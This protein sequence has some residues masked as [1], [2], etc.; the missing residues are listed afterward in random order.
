MPAVFVHGVPTT[1]RVW[2]RVRSLLPAESVA[3]ALP[4]MGA[5]RPDGFSATKDAYVQWLSEALDAIEGP[6][7]LVGHDWGSLLAL[8]V[9]G[10]TDRLRSWVGDVAN[11]YDPTYTWHYAAHIWQTPGEGEAWWA[12]SRASAPGSPGSTAGRLQR[13]GMPRD[14]AL[15]V[16]AA[17][18][19]TMV[20]SVL[21]LYR[22]AVPNLHA[23]WGAELPRAARTPGLVVVP[24]ADPFD[25]EAASRRTAE[26]TG[27]RTVT[28]DGLGH[29]WMA[30]DPQTAADT[31]TG[32][33]DSLD[34]A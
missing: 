21:D 17:D 6:I 14:Q 1:Y 8:R 28:L 4:G 7:D 31:L 32:F 19:E 30:Q 15:L 16:G 33:W 12:A 25:D 2:D 22:S 9:A 18:D 20:G 27:A 23:F 26:R 24:R 10:T 13:M 34:R 11:G 3:L 29:L 5:P